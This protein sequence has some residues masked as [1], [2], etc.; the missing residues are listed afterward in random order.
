MR[1]LSAEEI[2]SVAGAHFTVPLRVQILQSP[3][4]IDP[5]DP[6]L[7]DLPPGTVTFC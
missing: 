6:P 5:P 7:P 4:L 1:E 3:P 2:A